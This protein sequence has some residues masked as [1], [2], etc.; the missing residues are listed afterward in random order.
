MIIRRI[1]REERKRRHDPTDVAEPD[2]P[3]GPD[4]ASKVAFEV[5]NVPAERRGEGSEQAHGDEEDACVLGSDV[6]VDVQEDTDSREGD[7]EGDEGE[8]EAVAGAGG[9]EGYDQ[10]EGVSGCEGGNGVEL[11]FD[12][13]VLEA[14]DDG[15]EEVG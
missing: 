13:G 6:V 7:E 10:G 4:G 9:G 12:G 2:H 8:G 5:H 15:G 1:L 11:G 14:F 3:R